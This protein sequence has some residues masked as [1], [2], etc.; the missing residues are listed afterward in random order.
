M[1]YARSRAW[2][3]PL[4]M[5]AALAA[6]S[7]QPVRAQAP[8][9]AAMDAARS[10]YESLAETDRKAIQDALIW[11]GDY[12]GVTDGTF[13]RQTFAAITAYQRR[14]RQAPNGILTPQARTALL[15]AA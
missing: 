8:S 5:L 12:S 9:D 4:V 7:P 2:A 11:T 14:T 6:V 15:A 3:L 1:D 10:A 13:G